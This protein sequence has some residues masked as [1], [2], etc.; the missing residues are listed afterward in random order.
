[1]SNILLFTRFISVAFFVGLFFYYLGNKSHHTGL[2]YPIL[3]WIISFVFI[4]DTIWKKS[5]YSLFYIPFILLSLYLYF[6]GE[7]VPYAVWVLKYG[8]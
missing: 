6:S 2:D 7:L 4:V 3:A 5:R 1:M 8:P